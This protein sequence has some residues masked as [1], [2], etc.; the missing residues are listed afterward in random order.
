VTRTL[1]AVVTLALL[2]GCGKPVRVGA[3]VS[4]SGAASSYGEQVARG[5]DLAVQ[6]INDAGGVGGRRL[7]LLYRDDSTNAEVGL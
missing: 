1:P 4:R 2:A 7:E 6:Q 5:F 3:I